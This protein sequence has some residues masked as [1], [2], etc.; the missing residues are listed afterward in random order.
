MRFTKVLCGVTAA[1]TVLSSTAVV[2]QA[3]ALAEEMKL[4]TVPVSNLN[5][6]KNIGYMSSGY[7]SSDI[8]SYLKISSGDVA[9]WRETGELSFSVVECEPGLADLDL[10]SGDLDGGY[11][12]RVKRDANGNVTER[13][14]VHLDKAANKI[15][16]VYTMPADSWGYTNPD[17]YSVSFVESDKSVTL[18]VYD[19]S[20]KI[21]SSTLTYTGEDEMWYSGGATKGG[22]YVG[23]IMFKTAYYPPTGEGYNE[24]IH[25]YDL[26]LYL[27]KKSGEMV[28][29]QKEE[30]RGYFGTN[31]AVPNGMMWNSGLP[32]I[33]PMKYIYSFDSGKIFEVKN[34]DFIDSDRRSVSVSKLD[35]KLYGTKAIISGTEY[36]SQ[37]TGYVLVDLRDGARA[38]LLS[39]CY[40]NISTK[41]GKIY[42]VQSFDNKWGYIDSN[43]KELA[44][45]DDAGDF[46]GD[47]APVV[48]NG[49][50]YLIDRNMKK[51]SEE[52]TADGVTTMGDELFRIRN[53]S[54]YSLMTFAK[55][56]K[57]VEPNT[58][59]PTSEPTSSEPASSTASS[60]ETV[61]SAAS[62]SSA[63]EPSGSD[64][65]TTGAAMALI[66]VA[67]IGGGAALVVSRKRRK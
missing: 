5:G 18:N 8:N 25:R 42:L 20:G 67:L 10:W 11:L 13:R 27:I 22:E 48:K 32:P 57:P 54:N 65:P 55:A 44:F 49:K 37:E 62:D 9:N 50:A 31:G 61:S 60:S 43:G 41:D 53:G 59:T 14:V 15:S 6:A 56:D 46:N 63:A 23:Y 39:K 29:V 58:S 64:N 3:Q 2:A 28:L 66:P 34:S 51:V 38:E 16:T 45:F 24:S 17:G 7:F 40:K 35:G 1:L 52:I 33:A 19:P 36:E 12:Q 4:L 21:T 47:Y 26:D 30:G